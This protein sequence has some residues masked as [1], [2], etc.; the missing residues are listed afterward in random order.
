MT[1]TLADYYDPGYQRR[2]HLL[3]AVRLPALPNASAAFMRFA[4]T[5]FDFP[6]INACCRVDFDGSR[7][8][9][10]RILLGA[11]PR[12]AQ[13][14]RRAEEEIRTRGLT[15]AGIAEASVLARDE[16]VTRSG[17]VASGE[18]RTHLVG[19]LVERCLQRITERVEDR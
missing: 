10:A 4:R 12:R 11:T 18:Y 9:D 5:A 7:L 6:I 16:I 17:W 13:R 3:T 8:T 19:I 15:V 14:A 1:T 2:P